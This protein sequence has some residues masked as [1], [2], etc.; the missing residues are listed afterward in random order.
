MTTQS[1]IVPRGLVTEPSRL[2]A[3][4]GGLLQAH[5]IICRAPGLIET[6][7]SMRALPNATAASSGHQESYH[8]REWDGLTVTACANSAGT[9]MA[10]VR[11]NEA[12][13]LITLATSGTQQS[14]YSEV[15]DGRSMWAFSN[16][17]RMLDQSNQAAIDDN[18]I[19]SGAFTRMP[20][21]PRVAIDGVNIVPA[22][23]GWLAVAETTAYRVTCV[24]WILDDAGRR[25]PIEGPPSDRYVIENELG[26]A[27]IT[28]LRIRAYLNVRPGDELRIYRTPANG[29]AGA[30][31][32]DSMLL[33]G[34]FVV[35]DPTFGAVGPGPVTFDYVDV[36]TATEWSGPALYTN[37][38][39]EGALAAN[40]RLRLARD[41]A[42]Y[43]GKLFYAGATAGPRQSVVLKHVGPVTSSLGIPETLLSVRTQTATSDWAIGSPTISQVPA[44]TFPYLSIGQVVTAAASP[45]NNTAT[46]YG[47]ITA[48]SSGAGTITLDRNQPDTQVNQNIWIW[49]W[50]GFDYAGS[51]EPKRVFAPWI[52]IGGAA[53]LNAPVTSATALGTPTDGVMP[54]TIA[55]ANTVMFG[56]I[57]MAWND[58]QQPPVIF[59]GDKLRPF[60][61]IYTETGA[62]P[63]RGITVTAE[64]DAS[65][66]NPTDLEA[67][68][69]MNFGTVPNVAIVS[70]KAA[71]ASLP[72]APSYATAL[73]PANPAGDVATLWWSKTNQPESVPL[74]NFAIV[75]DSSEPI[76]RIF[77]T[78]DRL[79][80]LKTDGLWCVYGA[81]DTADAL[82]V[83]PV[84][85]TFRMIA[86]PDCS[87]W[88]CK[89][90]D[91]VYAWTQY[92]IYSIDS[93]GPIRI[94]DDIASLVRSLT[95]GFDSTQS[96]T[97]VAGR[98]FCGAS[99]R[100]QMIVFGAHQNAA[101]TV[102]G[103][104]LVYC[105]DGGTWA[106][107]DSIYIPAALFP[108][109]A[110][111][112]GVSES[113]ALRIPFQSGYV[114][115]TDVPAWNK[116]NASN[117]IPLTGDLFQY[118]P[119]LPTIA[120]VVG[121]VIT[122]NIPYPAG[123]RIRDS[124]GLWFRIVS[125]AG[126]NYTVDVS[127][128]TTGLTQEVHIS[129]P[130]IVK[131]AADQPPFSERHM[132]T[133]WHHWQRIRGGTRF[134][135]DWRA[136]GHVPGEASQYTIVYD[137]PDVAGYPT[138]IAN[139]LEFDYAVSV[140]IQT[141]R[142]RGLEVTVTQSEADVYWAIDGLT[143]DWNP[144]TPRIEK[145]R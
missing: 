59:P 131:Y 42:T 80:V 95:P 145:R 49:D 129:A 66:A 97:L 98:P 117:G 73:Y 36:A 110:A 40:Y 89:I 90:R 109:Y 127:G 37:D 7:P 111:G 138:T 60:A 22:A 143:I 100:D 106:T 87:A 135:V 2:V 93:R 38:G 35:P 96:A 126:A 113:G 41:L 91:T 130:R 57:E 125:I 13:P 51:T 64:W 102:P 115:L 16:G 34:S 15:A 144:E 3:G 17:L 104:C 72:L 75:G 142:V 92:G 86:N 69:G 55:V 5:N 123:S 139:D 76:V 63:S 48:F 43:Q 62:D 141:S 77:G 52:T 99:V 50:I 23:G 85:T 4:D 30:D 103:S 122:L 10:V 94:D 74:G 81:G 18:V 134:M 21:S 108:T 112:F 132:L 25:I 140:P 46:L 114:S 20:G 136:R 29:V 14:V 65:F 107:W 28:N 56:A 58:T 124:A 128:V 79:W 12:T 133:Q 116:A 137:D 61:R 44:S 121:K 27:A 67:T 83:Q 88:A 118:T 105:V 78:T 8:S 68:D 47:V 6:R 31:P 54:V 32:G 71:C 9:Q 101:G 33:R 1:R 45:L 53:T 84:D 70:S 119:T 24:R 19:G 39:I 11:D 82:T 26:G 120:T